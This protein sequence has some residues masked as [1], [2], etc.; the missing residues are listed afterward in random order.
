LEEPVP[1]YFQQ[2]S[3]LEEHSVPLGIEEVG[4]G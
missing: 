3:L 1:Q 2:Q 4:D